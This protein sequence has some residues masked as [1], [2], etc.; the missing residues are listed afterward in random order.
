MPIK[1]RILGKVASG[2]DQIKHGFLEHTKKVICHEAPL[3][4]HHD[5]IALFFYFSSAVCFPRTTA[6]VNVEPMGELK[7]M[8]SQAIFHNTYM[9][10]I[11]L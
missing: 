8:P 7:T 1:V 11:L 6:D 3:L 2:N 5:S 9:L 10:H 4:L